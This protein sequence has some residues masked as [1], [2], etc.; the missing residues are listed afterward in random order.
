MSI[1]SGKRESRKTPQWPRE[2]NIFSLVQIF[3]YLSNKKVIIIKPLDLQKKAALI[4]RF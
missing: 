3:K 2:N 1:H 4:S